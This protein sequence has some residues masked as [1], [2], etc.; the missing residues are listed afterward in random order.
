MFILRIGFTSG[1]IRKQD[2]VLLRNIELF[3]F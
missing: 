2:R 3:Y 1:N